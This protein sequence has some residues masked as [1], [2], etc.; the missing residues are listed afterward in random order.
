MKMN[1]NMLYLIHSWL[2]KA[3]YGTIVNPAL[4]SL[5][6]WVLSAINVSIGTQAL[7]RSMPNHWARSAINVSTDTSV[8][9]SIPN[10]WGR[11]SI[12]L[13]RTRTGLLSRSNQSWVSISTSVSGAYMLQVKVNRC[14]NNSYVVI[15][16]D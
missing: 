14:N 15:Y 1:K 10:Q 3:F 4:P 5:H 16:I 9:L 6:K 13:F 7:N 2:G 8:Q 11:S 12:Y